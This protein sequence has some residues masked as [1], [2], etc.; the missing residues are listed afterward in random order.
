[1][2]LVRSMDNS[3]EL[4]TD[5]EPSQLLSSADRAHV[6]AVGCR[7]V[8]RAQQSPSRAA[9]GTARLQAGLDLGGKNSQVNERTVFEGARADDDVQ[10]AIGSAIAKT[11]EKSSTWAP[12]R[13]VTARIVAV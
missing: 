8:R 12:T 13:S 1:M 10:L 2:A 11:T 4:P 5:D 3:R 6:K 7:L 9:D